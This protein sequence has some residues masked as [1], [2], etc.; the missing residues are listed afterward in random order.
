MRVHGPLWVPCILIHSSNRFDLIHLTNPLKWIQ[1]SK[2]K[3]RPFNLTAICWS[4]YAKFA[5]SD[6]VYSVCWHHTL[7]DYFIIHSEPLLDRL[8]RMTQRASSVSSQSF[9]ISG[10][11]FFAYLSLLWL[12]ASKLSLTAKSNRTFIVLQTTQDSQF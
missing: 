1:F 11:L 8:P 10:S 3:I 7:T 5:N 4:L 12:I 9:I 2:K 6:C